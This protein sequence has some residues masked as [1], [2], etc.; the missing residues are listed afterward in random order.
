M[1]GLV[2]SECR[3]KSLYKWANRASKTLAKLKYVGMT[4]TNKNVIH[5]VIKSS[6][7]ANHLI[8]LNV[9]MYT[10]ASLFNVY[11]SWSCDNK[12]QK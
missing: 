12:R 1:Y 3:T 8:L 7:S 9:V 2:T 11:I 6:S 10:F 5:K 4:V